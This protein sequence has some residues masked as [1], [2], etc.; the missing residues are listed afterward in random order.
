MSRSSR[1]KTLS[2]TEIE[3]FL[4]EL[5]VP[6]PIN[7]DVNKANQ[8]QSQGL[9]ESKY[10]AV[11]KSVVGA[12]EEATWV[13]EL[14]KVKLQIICAFVILFW[15]SQLKY[16]SPL[17]N[18]MQSSDAMCKLGRS[19][20]DNTNYPILPVRIMRPELYEFPPESMNSKK[21]LLLSL[22]PMLTDNEAQRK[23]DIAACEDFTRCRSS[24][25]KARFSNFEYTDLDTGLKVSFEEYERR[26]AFLL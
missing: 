23:F 12:K 20:Q 25:G 8:S 14:C 6:T 22:T 3:S 13:R 1:R 18:A 7:D 11:D 17:Q 5:T 10:V 19:I 9:T 2:H 15:F 24:K 26:C 21:K 16:R 4:S